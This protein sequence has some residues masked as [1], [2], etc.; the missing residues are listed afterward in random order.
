[1]REDYNKEI[2]EL[3]ADAVSNGMNSRDVGKQL[4]ELYLSDRD[5]KKMRHLFCLV[6]SRMEPEDIKFTIQ[7]L[8]Y[9]YKHVRD[10]FEI[11]ERVFIFHSIMGSIRNNKIENIIE[12]RDAMIEAILYYLNDVVDLN[13]EFQLFR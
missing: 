8:G 3:L 7:W 5:N 1:M 10:Y 4:V 2:I 11:E 12:C 13:I 9:R 6:L